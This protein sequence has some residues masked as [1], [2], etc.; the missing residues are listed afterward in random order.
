MAK[1]AR[2]RAAARTGSGKG[3][4]EPVD[5]H[6]GARVTSPAASPPLRRKDSTR[7]RRDPLLWETASLRHAHGQAAP[8]LPIAQA[9]QQA[10]WPATPNSSAT[11]LRFQQYPKTFL[12]TRFAISVGSNVSPGRTVELHCAMLPPPPI[13]WRLPAH[14][15]G[16]SPK[17]KMRRPLESQF[18]ETESGGGFRP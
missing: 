14:A 2:G 18:G 8:F 15:T 11:P 13:R 10:P 5:V 9:S 17:A 3:G 16:F 1:P 4:S 6:V 12:R 7:R